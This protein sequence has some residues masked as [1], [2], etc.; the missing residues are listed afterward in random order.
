[1]NQHTGIG[2]VGNSRASEPK[3]ELRHRD[4]FKNPMTAVAPLVVMGALTFAWVGAL[5]YVLLMLYF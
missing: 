5:L 2:T 1:M 4:D 3:T